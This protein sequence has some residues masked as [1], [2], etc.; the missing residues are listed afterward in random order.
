MNETVAKRNYLR[1]RDLRILAP[2][3]T[4]YTTRRFAYDL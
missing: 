2:V 1:P 3:L 4:A